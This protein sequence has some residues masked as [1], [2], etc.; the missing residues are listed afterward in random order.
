MTVAELPA[1]AVVSEK[2]QEH[3][4]RIS[5]II[6]AL[7]VRRNYKKPWY[8]TRFSP[9]ALLM[10]CKTCNEYLP[11][12]DFYVKRTSKQPSKRDILGQDH[13]DV[14]IKCTAKQYVSLDPRRKLYYSAKSRANKKGIFFDISV[15]DIVIPRLCPVFGTKLKANVGSG[16]VSFEA[17]DNSPTLD[18]IDNSRGY[19]ADNICVISLRA[20]NL[21]RDATLEELRLLAFYM[22]NPIKLPIR[23][24]SPA[25]NSRYIAV[26]ETG[27]YSENIKAYLRTDQRVKMLRSMKQR[28]KVYGFDPS[29]TKEDIV[30]PEFCP[31]L[32]IKIEPCIGRGSQS[33][34][35]LHGSP[36]IDRID[37][38][39]GYVK[40]NIQVISLRAN[41][42]KGNAT[43]QEVK[44]LL[45]Y[46][47][48]VNSEAMQ[49]AG[50]TGGEA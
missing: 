19:I 22:E 26:S 24:I 16:A 20:N 43:L 21:K 27:M 40:G 7:P 15:D 11:V 44:A 38:S 31:I 28:G 8:R 2:D 32:G 33:M 45:N 12:V 39:R 13:G 42:I 41:W 6:D 30:I 5:R 47:K 9:C 50:T 37:S 23:D 17:L 36:S 10:Q 49:C 1:L 29:L 4:E 18:R 34:R 3:G 48:T 25:I 14:C 46:M 35:N